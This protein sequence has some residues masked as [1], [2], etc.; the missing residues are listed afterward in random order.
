MMQPALQG[1]NVNRHKARGLYRPAPEQQALHR[2][3]GELR[4]RCVPVGEIA[5]RVYVSQSTVRRH[6]A[7]EC[8]CLNGRAKTEAAGARERPSGG[9]RV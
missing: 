9:D 2:R 1:V 5:V 7:C 6:L 8:N 4:Q 3:I